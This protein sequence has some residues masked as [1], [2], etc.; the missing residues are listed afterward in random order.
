MEIF[1]KLGRMAQRFGC[2]I[3]VTMIDSLVI[4][5]LAVVPDIRLCLVPPRNA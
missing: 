5:Q 2:S 1:V 3:D 4:S